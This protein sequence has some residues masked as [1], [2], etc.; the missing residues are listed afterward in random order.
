M[1]CTC[2]SAQRPVSNRP[3]TSRLHRLGRRCLRQLLALWIRP[4]PAGPAPQGIDPDQPVCYLLERYALTDLLALSCY[5]RRQHLPDPL[6]AN[7]S[8]QPRLGWL[9][10]PRQT[11]NPILIDALEAQC[12]QP[13]PLQLVPATLF[14]GRAPSQEGSLVK[15]LLSLDN[16]LLQGFQQFLAVLLNGRQ[17]QVQLQTPQTAAQLYPAALPPQRR[18]RHCSRVLRREFRATRLAA[19]GPDLSQR[20]TVIRQVLA[21]PLVRNEIR[22]QAEA[23]GRDSAALQQEARR[24]VDEIASDYRYSVLRLFDRLLTWFWNKLYSGVNVHHSASL[25][26]LAR[27]HGIVYVPCHRSHIDYLLLSYVLFYQGLT[28]P[29]IAAGINLNMPLV[30]TLLRRAGAFFIRRSFRGQALYAAVFNAYLQTLLA[31]GFPIEYFVEGGRSRTGRTLPPKIGMLLM[32]LQGYLRE[33][34]KP[35]LFIPVYIGYERV[36]EGNTYLGE[37]RGKQK[38]KETP[39]DILRSLAALKRSFGEVE[40]SFGQAI[41]LDSLI[42]NQPHVLDPDRPETLK[43]LCNTLAEQIAIGINC[44]VAVNAVNL[45]ALCLLASPR[46]TLAREALCAQMERYRALLQQL[47]IAPNIS[48]PEG[49]TAQLLD[50][51]LELGLVQQ[52]SDGLGELIEAQGNQAVL[53]TY[54]RNNIQHL[55]LLPSLIASLVQHS[56]GIERAALQTLIQQ[57]YPYLQNELF[58]PW[59]ADTLPQ[60]IE[61]TLEA[62]A[63]QGLVRLES[64]QCLPP[65]PDSSAAVALQQLGELCSQS[66]QRYYMVL[67]LLEQHGSN[68]LDADALEARCKLLAQRLAS[69]HGINA[70]EFSDQRL[71]RQFVS[72]LL[73][74]GVLS[75]GPADRLCFD[76]RIPLIVEHAALLLSPPVRQSIRQIV[77]QPQQ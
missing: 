22:R 40:L 68:R 24:Y 53:L 66:L 27:D 12:Q 58:L 74:R 51:V 70:P 42:E 16:V 2:V 55:F 76:R 21:N 77:L 60:A 8:G 75:L 10:G 36:F 65:A 67:S 73:T 50:R 31:R 6:A 26:A 61:D 54:Y 64:G 4:Q 49:D 15:L 14:W 11:P 5:C 38:K 39:L 46:Q 48:L 20:A 72:L 59:T 13:T 25:Q 63:Q 56:Q 23:C 19:V 45:V 34:R 62:L 3:R 69:C 35:L 7:A 30:G 37:L 57:I 18:R 32:T 52:R 29:H 41:A 1:E 47:A 17:L 71:F 33:R 43:P 9:E 44:A 28:P